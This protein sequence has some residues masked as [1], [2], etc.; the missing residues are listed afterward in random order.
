MELKLLN[1]NQFDISF[2]LL[3]VPYGIETMEEMD[4]R[5]RINL[6]IVP[7]GIETQ[8]HR[9]SDSQCKRLLIVPYGIETPVSTGAVSY[10]QV[11]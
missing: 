6:L 5:M 1:G 4:E 2:S 11:F 7:Y 3:I 10:A 9:A 8:E